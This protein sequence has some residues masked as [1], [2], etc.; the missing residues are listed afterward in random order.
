M[1]YDEKEPRPEEE[2]KQV[3]G[4]PQQ[5]LLAPWIGFNAEKLHAPPQTPRIA[6]VT[7]FCISVTLKWL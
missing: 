6:R 7:R 3:P 5:D 4:H 2:P 1:R